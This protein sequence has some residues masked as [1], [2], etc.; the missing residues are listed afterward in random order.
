MCK[1]L[2]RRACLQGIGP[3]PSEVLQQVSAL[4]SQ[5]RRGRW[6]VARHSLGTTCSGDGLRW[7]GCRCSNSLQGR[8]R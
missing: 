1:D 5:A 8:C 3:V 2:E 6:R 7:E 4:G